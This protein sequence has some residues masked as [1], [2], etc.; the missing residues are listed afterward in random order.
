MTVFIALLRGINVGGHRKIKMDELKRTLKALGLERVQTYIQ[1]GN[2]LFASQEEAALL[3]SRIERE[4]EA[5]FGFPVTTVLRSLGELEQIVETCPFSVGE[6]A[7]G[8][9]I[10]IAFL[11]EQPAPVRLANLLA[12]RSETDECR[13]EG[14]NVYVL[15][16]QGLRHTLFTNNFFESKLAVAA[17]M[18]NW[19]T[20]CKLVQMGKAIND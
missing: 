3:R 20:T 10:C 13:V 4:I 1:S 17:T 5:A 11:A 14:Q 6:L 2:V 12:Y 7:D 16:R 18:R 9:S 15:C 19:Q 8:E